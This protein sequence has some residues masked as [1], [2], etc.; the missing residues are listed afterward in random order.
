MKQCPAQYPRYP[1]AAI[2]NINHRPR[3]TERERSHL[4]SQLPFQEHHPICNSIHRHWSTYNLAKGKEICHQLWQEVS[5]SL[6]NT[7]WENSYAEYKQISN[8]INLNTTWDEDAL[9]RLLGCH[10]WN[11]IFERFKFC[12]IK[13]FFCKCVALFFIFL[14]IAG[15]LASKNTLFLYTVYG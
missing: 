15:K 4:Y 7:I 14:W 10:I 5:W 2:V 1:G 9:F 3:L 11:D 8:P 12:Y 6:S 13:D